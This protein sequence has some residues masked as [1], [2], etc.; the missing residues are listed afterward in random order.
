MLDI[1]W[2]WEHRIGELRFGEI[3]VIVSVACEAPYPVDP[4]NGLDILIEAVAVETMQRNDTGRGPRFVAR[5][6]WLPQ[7]DDLVALI[8]HDLARDEDFTAHVHEVAFASAGEDS[9]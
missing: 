7:D 6:H 3:E 9:S 2:T 1:T 8:C 4:A 5:R